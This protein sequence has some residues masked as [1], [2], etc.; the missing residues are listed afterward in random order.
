MLPD[1]IGA[2][3]QLLRDFGIGQSLTEKSQNLLFA[4]SEV[5]AGSD[6]RGRLSSRGGRE[7]R[8][9]CPWDGI[10]GD[11]TRL[12]YS[13][14]QGEISTSRPYLAHTRRPKL[15]LDRG[16][17]LIVVMLD[18][19]WPCLAHGRPNTRGR[20]KQARSPLWVAALCG[21]DP[22]PQDDVARAHS[23]AVRQRNGE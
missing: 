2:D 22:Q 20:A 17:G 10:Q 5:D 9:R 8:L 23:V 18:I 1:R 12:C 16:H 13:L 19:A 11:G 6:D 4:A 7:C 15:T 3:E 21:D 14:V